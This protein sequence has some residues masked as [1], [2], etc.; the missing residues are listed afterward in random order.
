MDNINIEVALESIIK[1]VQRDPELS[2]SLLEAKEYFTKVC[3]KIQS[4]DVNY[5][6]RINC[7]LNWF[8]FDWRLKNNY[9]VFKIIVSKFG[10]KGLHSSCYQFSDN[11]HSL[12]I[13]L[14]ERRSGYLI[15]D[16]FSKTKYLIK[17]D[18]FFQT[19]EKKSCFETRIFTINQL[20]C[21]SNYLILHPIG[22][23]SYIQR[24]VKNCKNQSSNLSE[25]LLQLHRSYYKWYT[26]KHFSLKQIYSD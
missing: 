15:Y 12:F 4:V 23:M 16:L 8:L 19:V 6:N 18:S 13:F 2:T 11:I 9:S 24:A 22:A 26:Y 10:E 14:K 21:F 17:K 5:Q 1:F 7:F 3:G 25:L 20:N